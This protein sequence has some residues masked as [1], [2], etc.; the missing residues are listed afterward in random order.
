MSYSIKTIPVFEQDFK[1]LVKKYPSLKSDLATLIKSLKDIPEQGTPL[2][3]SCFKIRM[4][5]K[6]E[7]RPFSSPVP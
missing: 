5:V 1:K 4:A 7:L 6:R 3:K 2:G